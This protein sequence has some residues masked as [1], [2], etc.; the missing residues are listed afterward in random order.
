MPVQG[1]K[2]TD[3]RAGVKLLSALMKK[4]DSEGNA[5]AR[6]SKTEL[7][8]FVDSWGD[9]ASL[10]GALKKVYAYAQKRF[11]VQS[12]SIAQLNKALADAM[13]GVAKGDKNDSGNISPT[14]KRALADTW[15]AVVDFSKDYKGHGVRDVMGLN[16]AP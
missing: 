2:L 1:T 6:V 11:D 3:V 15:K 14:E 5:N 12:P 13:A 7:K 16:N 4:I 8:D 10:D 9:G